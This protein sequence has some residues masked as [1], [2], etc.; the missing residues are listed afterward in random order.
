MPDYVSYKPGDTVPRSGIYRIEHAPHR[1]MHE[2]TLLKGALFPCCKRCRNSVRFE[3]VRPMN[4]SLVIPF[5][6]TAILEPFPEQELP[7]APAI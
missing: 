5:R 1:L 3:L 6:E 7:F 2:A 4:E